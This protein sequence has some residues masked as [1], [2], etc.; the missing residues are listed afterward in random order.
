[1]RGVI[2][3]RLHQRAAA[4]KKA[5]GAAGNWQ[6]AAVLPPYRRL[7]LDEAHHLEDTAA[8]H[9]GAQATSR[10]VERLLSRLERG[11]RGVLSALNRYDLQNYL[12]M[13]QTAVR[14]IGV[15]AVLRTGHGIIAI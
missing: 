13:V 11:K 1:M 5:R 9:L 8:D 7:V 12:S 14:V 4:S 3:L 15:V 6:D 10:G 2:C